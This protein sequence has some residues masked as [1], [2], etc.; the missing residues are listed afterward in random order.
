MKPRTK[1]AGKGR[2]YS[3]KAQNQ[4][5]NQ[6]QQNETKKQ[7]SAKEQFAKRLK[8]LG[9]AV[10]EAGYSHVGNLVGGKMNYAGKDGFMI[11]VLYSEEPGDVRVFPLNADN[12][13]TM[14]EA[15]SNF[16]EA[17]ERRANAISTPFLKKPNIYQVVSLIDDSQPEVSEKVKKMIEYTEEKLAENVVALK[18]AR[19]LVGEIAKEVRGIA[20][21]VGREIEI[22][23]ENAYPRVGEK[24]IRLTVDNEPF[25]ITIQNLSRETPMEEFRFTIENEQGKLADL[26]VE[27]VVSA[28]SSRLTDRYAENIVQEE[29]QEEPAQA[30]PR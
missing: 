30:E 12:E 23:Y 20:K 6:Q 9:F 18:M 11:F 15:L 3:R 1:N 5:Q 17:V 24:T 8:R 13:K 22:E 16:K 2:K 25:V 28:I 7:I 29:E 19:A 14:K 10:Q 4:N 27:S 21:E 26:T